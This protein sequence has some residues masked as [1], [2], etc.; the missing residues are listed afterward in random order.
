MQTILSKRVTRL[1]LDRAKF[2]R[3]R[4]PKWYKTR[5]NMITA[6]DIATALGHN[7]YETPRQL[8]TRKCRASIVNKPMS[9]A[10]EWGIKYEPFALDLYKK[11]HNPN[12]H[13]FGLIPH[14]RYKWLGASPDGIVSTGKVLE[15]K[16][17][18]YRSVSGE[19]PYYYW[20]QSQ[21]LMEV[22]NLNE[23]DFFQCKFSEYKNYDHYSRDIITDNKGILPIEEGDDIYWRLD[24]YAY[25]TIPRDYRW[26]KQNKDELFNFWKKVEKDRESS[27]HNKK[28]KRSDSTSSAMVCSIT[29]KR[30]KS[31]PPKRSL[32]R[33]RSVELDTSL[34]VREKK[35]RKKEEKAILKKY[36]FND[37]S[38]WVFATATRNY[39]LKD[40][41]LDWLNL[42]GNSNQNINMCLDKIVRKTIKTKNGQT[43]RIKNTKF[44]KYLRTDFPSEYIGSKTF[45]QFVKSKGLHFESTI[46]QKLYKKY[47]NDII[48]IANQHQCRAPEKFIETQNAI[49]K[50]IPI[51][52][53][54]VLYNG[55]NR[56]YGMPD[57]LIRSDW[58]TKIFL[59]T[60]LDD[61]F[62]HDPAPL[63]QS[64]SDPR[65]SHEEWHYRVVEIKYNT[66]PLRA[67]GTHLLNSGSTPAHKSQLWVY[68]QALGEMQGYVPNTTYIFGRKWKY[69]TKGI[70][71]SG[72]DC[73][74]KLGKINYST[75]D[76]QYIQKT[77]DAIEWMRDLKKNG[78]KWSLIPPER[79]EMYPNMCNHSDAL[80]RR[81]KSF[82]AD[83]INEITQL[84]MCG[85]KNRL[86]AHNNGI[87]DWKSQECVS[88]D[89]GINGKKQAK[90][91]QAIIDINKSETDIINV[92]I[93][94]NNKYS[95]Q[96]KPK[97]EFFI[98]FEFLT[99]IVTDNTDECLIFMIGVGWISP[100]TNKWKYK[101]FT[102]DHIN[103]YEEQK[104]I[105][106]FHNYIQRISK[107]YSDSGPTH[108]GP[109][110]YHWGHIER[111][112]YNTTYQKHKSKLDKNGSKKLINWCDFLG[113]MKSEPIAIK[114]ALNYSIKTVAKA[115]YNNKMIKTKWATNYSGVSDGFTAMIKAWNCDRDALKKDISLKKLPTIKEI[116]KYNEVD[117]KVLWD[118]INYLRV[119]HTSNK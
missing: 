67:D 14:K 96:K 35:R 78:N 6:S 63:L 16:C 59:D 55:T 104:I 94:R 68:N 45:L 36:K 74:D 112:C 69:K 33:K 111:T 115:M 93:I 43:R 54:G 18:L 26:F 103:F 65:G 85:A 60:D 108:Q 23:C 90:I 91:L 89:F 95:W 92:D 29:K 42:Y 110:L 82:I 99:D 52:Y 88:E 49:I 19:I 66:L 8:L 102:C 77:E 62:I 2:P 5:H 22:C 27:K 24:D 32:K 105:V 47:P 83:E 119:N 116:T 57:L 48:T 109:N 58:L 107:K 113:V 56:T 25:K 75:I 79:E 106:Q 50:G 38:D 64:G 61:D 11:M 84:W 12:V 40:P 72:D 7:M 30:K 70:H 28:R 4:T 80:W 3:Q 1:L 46:I 73:F 41:L 76:E 118:I 17:P 117:C 87:Y 98:D 101:N 13:E 97:L 15:I 21:I 39:V 44:R 53:S 34:E 86:I 20:I 114:G 9:T 37:W 31:V 81:T 71:Y 51:I 100:V 10:M